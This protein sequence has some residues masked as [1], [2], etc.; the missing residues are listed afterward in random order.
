MRTTPLPADFI[1]ARTCK[2]KC[3]KFLTRPKELR[4][5]FAWSGK[6]KKDMPR[7]RA[8]RGTSLDFVCRNRIS[9][10]FEQ[11]SAKIRA[12]HFRWKAR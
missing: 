3:E 9:L 12:D 7:N 5:M 4:W 1:Y 2:L 6:N 11:S 8:F 10:Y